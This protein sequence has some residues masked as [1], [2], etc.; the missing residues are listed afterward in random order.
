[1]ANYHLVCHFAFENMEQK[2]IAHLAI[3]RHRTNA[4]WLVLALCL[5]IGGDWRNRAGCVNKFCLI[6]TAAKAI[7]GRCEELLQAA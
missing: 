4:V 5:F 7:G 2:M 1:M 6:P 3:N